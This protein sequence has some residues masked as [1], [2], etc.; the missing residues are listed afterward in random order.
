M[1]IEIV[2]LVMEEWKVWK[3]SRGVEMVIRLVIR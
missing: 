1:A 3:G 2:M